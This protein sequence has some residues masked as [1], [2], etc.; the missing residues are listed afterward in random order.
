MLLIT[1]EGL[2]RIRRAS[3]LAAIAAERGISTRPAGS[4]LVA[5][6]PFDRCGQGAGR[7]LLIEPDS[8]IFRCLVC[9]ERG[10]VVGF[11]VKHDRVTYPQALELLA[12]RAGLDLAEVMRPALPARLRGGHRGG[13]SAHLSALTPPAWW[14]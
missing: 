10:D 1:R 11:V 7:S 14:K 13:I 4:L 8:G 12:L 5:H 6:C 9:G 2:R 3:P